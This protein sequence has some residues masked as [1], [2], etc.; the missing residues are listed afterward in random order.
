M[1]WEKWTDPT[2]GKEY[3]IGTCGFEF[4]KQS[5]AF[6]YYISRKTFSILPIS[7]ASFSVS[8]AME[9]DLNAYVPTY[10]SWGGPGWSAG[11]RVRSTIDWTDHPSM[12][13][14]VKTSPTPENKRGRSSKIKIAV[15]RQL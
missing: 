1:S 9:R 14:N 3:E 5:A 8:Y 6:L 11:T 4:D 13:E 10:G 2:T 12:N 7:I 15:C